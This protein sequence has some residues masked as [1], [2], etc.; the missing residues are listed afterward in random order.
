MENEYWYKWYRSKKGLISTLWASQRRKSKTRGHPQPSYT[1]QDLRDWLYSQ[2]KF[3]ELFDEWKI[4]GYDT[5]SKPS[6]DRIND[7]EPYTLANIQLLSWQENQEKAYDSLRK[8]ENDR[9]TAFP[10]AQ[11]TKSGELL[12]TYCS[13]K[14]ASRQTGVDDYLIALCARG[15]KNKKHAGGYVWRL[16]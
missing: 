6:V 9:H 14:E 2:P 16:A 13:F 4:S 15:S 8:G 7:N 12:N 1:K 5:A 11:F 10:V 3:H